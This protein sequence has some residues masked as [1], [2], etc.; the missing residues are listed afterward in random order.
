MNL[1]TRKNNYTSV[2]RL[3]QF[4]MHHLVHSTAT[5]TYHSELLQL[6][7]FVVQPLVHL[8]V[9]KTSCSQ[10]LYPTY[11]YSIWYIFPTYQY[12]MIALQ[13]QEL[14]TTFYINNT[15]NTANHEQRNYLIQDYDNIPS[16]KDTFKVNIN[17]TNMSHSQHLNT[18]NNKQHDHSTPI[19]FEEAMNGPDVFGFMIAMDKETRTLLQMKTFIIVN[20]ETSSWVFNRQSSVDSICILII[21]KRNHSA[22]NLNFVNFVNHSITIPILKPIT[23]DY[24]STFQSLTQLRQIQLYHTLHFHI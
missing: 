12:S 15:V 22:T 20:K 19:S 4:L 8:T 24:R 23:S 9:L 13:Q 1:T 7:Q 2:P 5:K 17:Q 3:V 14:Y 6:A 21:R 18:Y 16:L 10:F 11:Q